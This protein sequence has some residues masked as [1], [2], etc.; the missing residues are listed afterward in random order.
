MRF[1]S[2]VPRT[3][4]HLT[5][6]ILTFLASARA[7]RSKGAAKAQADAVR[8]KSRRFISIPGLLYQILAAALWRLV[9]KNGV[10]RACVC[11]LFCHGLS[12]Q[13]S[14]S[15]GWSA[16]SGDAWE[17]FWKLHASP[18]PQGGGGG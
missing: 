8:R 1:Q 12:D 10:F 2:Q 17:A 6:V 18:Q 9:T 11:E 14:V 13:E 7:A 5:S 16:K 15:C 4:M 3:I